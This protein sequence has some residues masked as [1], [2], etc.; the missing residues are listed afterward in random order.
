MP[1][2]LNVL[3]V[4]DSRTVLAQIERILI[5]IPDVAVT[6]RFPDLGSGAGLEL[7]GDL[8]YAVDHQVAT[9]ETPERITL[10]LGLRYA[11]WMYPERVGVMVRQ[12]VDALFAAHPAL[13]ARCVD[14]SLVFRVVP[15]TVDAVPSYDSK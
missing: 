7:T 3:L 14:G 13:A 12:L 10:R 5:E 9:G 11:P 4:D 8:H 2:K 6:A 15:Q 1:R